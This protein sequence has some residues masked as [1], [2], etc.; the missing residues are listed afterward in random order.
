MTRARADGD[1]HAHAAGELAGE[2]AGGG[3]E[4]DLGEGGGDALGGVVAVDAGEVEREADVGV[5]AG[6]GHEGG[7]L[8]D[9]GEAA[10]GGADLLER[11]VP[12][13]DVAFAGFDEVGG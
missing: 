2:A 1:A 4:V 13:E 12:P 3:E 6:P 8:E 11:L 7:V 9:E 10:A 5:D